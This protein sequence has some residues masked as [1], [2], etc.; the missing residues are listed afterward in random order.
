MDI[1]SL[2][3][4]FVIACIV[5]V[6]AK[7]IKWPYTITLVI[8]GII[9]AV[10]GI[11][12]PFPLDRD[13]LFQVLLPPL[14]FEGALHMRMDHLKQN[15]KVILLLIIPG[16]MF[17]VF[18]TGIILNLLF[19]QVPLIF[20]LLLAAIVIPTDPAAILAF[21]R[22]MKVPKKLKSIIEGESVFDDGLAIVLFNVMIGI[23][24]AAS[25]TSGGT[26]VVTSENILAGVGE[27]FKLSFLGILLG[28]GIGYIAVQLLK[29]IDD[30]F[31]EIMITVIL[32]FG[33][34][35]LAEI[36]GASGV[37]A[38]VIAGLI[39]GN[40]GTRFAMAPSTRMSLINF[41]SFMSFGVNSIL[42]IIIGMNVGLQAIIDNIWIIIATVLLLWAARAISICA[43]GLA[44]NRKKQELSGNGQVMMWW[45]GLRGAIPIVMALSIPLF[46]ADGTTPFPHKELIL[47]ITFGVVLTTLL[48]QGLS[49]R[50]VLKRLGYQANA[51]K[52]GIDEKTANAIMRD[53]TD[54]LAT[55]NEDGDFQD[56]GYQ[57]LISKFSQANSVLLT[58][59][60]TLMKENGFV[61][62]EEYLAAVRESL[63]VKRNAVKEAMQKKLILGE[64]AEKLIEEIDSQIEGLTAD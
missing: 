55:L 46:L 25:L 12:A 59:M 40:Y 36:I 44:V 45:G 15:S 9:V 47:T 5:A 31:T 27:F 11:K 50:S 42:F 61:P 58:E 19:P 28:L 4:I 22:D 49:L 17:A 34:F 32:A 48:V 57:L 30:K 63:T 3:I 41:W 6:L 43:I 54:I 64:A 29:K 13:I 14:L 53:T 24:L 26:M 33:T 2:I 16:L 8:A 20:T 37:F 18:F 39:L 1:N 56:G 52:D 38:V 35:A 51:R 7:L 23:I 60:G 21:Y 62:K 10:L